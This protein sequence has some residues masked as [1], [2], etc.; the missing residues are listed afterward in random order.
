MSFTITQIKGFIEDVYIDIVVEKFIGD[1]IS[2][3][4]IKFVEKESGKYQELN[5]DEGFAVAFA[6]KILNIT[7]TKK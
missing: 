6:D 5:M 3:I 4:K 2:R 1:G 7:S